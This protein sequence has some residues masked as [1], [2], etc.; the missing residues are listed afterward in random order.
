M[1]GHTYSQALIKAPLS[2]ETRKERRALLAAS[3]ISILIAKTG[4]VPT[5]IAALGIEFSQTERT[6]FLYC[7]L[8][9]VIYFLV[10]FIAYA[11][12]DFWNLKID[13]Q[14]AMLATIKEHQEFLDNLSKPGLSEARRLIDLRKS[15]KTQDDLTEDV[16]KEI[17]ELEHNLEYESQRREE[18]LGMVKKM[19]GGM[20][21]K[22]AG[23]VSYA[24]AGF[25]FLIPL[26][27]A[28][29]AIIILLSALR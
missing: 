25:D 19:E 10:A 24:R 1:P 5:K 27:V 12:A 21:M 17:S 16:R 3:G 8:A 14:Q 18:L 13:I 23:L 20:I 7:L 4:L 11:L 28:G 26:V 15:L 2:E 22:G 9:M 29:A 6:T